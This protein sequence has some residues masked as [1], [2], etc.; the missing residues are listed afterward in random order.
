[1]RDLLAI[2]KALSDRNRL[3][4]FCALVRHG[5]LCVC[6][7]QELLGLAVSTTSR[8]LSLLAA[9]RLVESR[10]DGRWVHYRIATDDPAPGLAGVTAWVLEQAE[11]SPVLAADRGRLAAILAIPPEELCQRQAN[12]QRCCSSAP[13]TPAAARSRK[14]TP[15]R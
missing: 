1:M 11:S 12:G 3:R 13:E 2:T 6:Q 4:A 15:A 9:A 14:A 7:L 10:K 5:E 8:H